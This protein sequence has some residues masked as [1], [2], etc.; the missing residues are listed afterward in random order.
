M[1]RSKRDVVCRISGSNDLWYC[2]GKTGTE[3]VLKPLPPVTS[4]QV[5]RS[6]DRWELACGSGEAA[7]LDTFAKESHAERARWRVFSAMRDGR[8][9]AWVRRLSYLA[10]AV[11]MFVL[12]VGRTVGTAGAAPQSLPTLGAT[13]GS[14]AALNEASRQKV[15][16]SRIDLD[17]TIALGTVGKPR[18]YVFSDPLCPACQYLETALSGTAGELDIRVVP[19]PTKGQ[20]SAGLVAQSF[21]SPDAAGA[22]RRI[23]QGRPGTMSETNRDK[24]TGCV[25]RGLD[26]YNLFKDLAL[27]GT[28]TLIA[29]D[30]RV[31]VGAVTGPELLAWVKGR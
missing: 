19:V 17:H 29:G 25:Q 18:V 11:L 7:V 4:L 31:H 1:F 10:L 16:V 23:M 5:R 13:D 28:P 3:R 30:G 15:D 21:C 20:E 8:Y 26:N 24:L 14:L 27:S 2:F 12:L 6:G 9:G 22:W